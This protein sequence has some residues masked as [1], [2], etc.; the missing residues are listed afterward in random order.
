VEAVTIEGRA[1][2]IPSKLQARAHVVFMFAIDIGFLYSDEAGNAE[3]RRELLSRRASGFLTDLLF[4]NVV[5]LRFAGLDK[6]RREKNEILDR[7]RR[8]ALAGGK[9]IWSASLLEQ[10]APF[11]FTEASNTEPRTLSLDGTAA[12]KFDCS[13]RRVRV[14]PRGVISLDQTW[15]LAN[16]PAELTVE[17]FIVAC[18]K[19]RTEALDDAWTQIRSILLSLPS[20]PEFSSTSVKLRETDATAET[21]IRQ[22]LIRHSMLFLESVPGLPVEESVSF[23]GLSDCEKK[24]MVGVLNLT[25]WY[26]RYS[27][28]YVRSVFEHVVKESRG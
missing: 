13:L 28:D 14:F 1:L 20:D 10:E 17:Q 3:A 9:N 22:H 18:K 19:A 25:E 21:F 8:A 27:N 24:P 4:D 15:T 2:E 16:E 6:G 12:A 23:D 26:K 11:V 7:A 5:N